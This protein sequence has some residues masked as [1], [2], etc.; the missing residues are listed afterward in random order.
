MRNW[1][2]LWHV[3]RLQ[4]LEGLGTVSVKSDHSEIVSDDQK[5]AYLN[6][7]RQINGACIDDV[8]LLPAWEHSKGDPTPRPSHYKKV[9]P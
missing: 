5:D 7:V 1:L 9:T 2:V 8:R 6:K 4:T 3:S